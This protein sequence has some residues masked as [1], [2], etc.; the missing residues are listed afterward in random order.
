MQ[1]FPLTCSFATPEDIP[2]LICLVD[3]VFTRFEAPDYPVQGVTEFLKY[4]DESAWI[5]R[6][7]SGAFTIMCKKGEAIAGLIEIREGNHL[8]LLFVDEKYHRLGI[9]THLWQLAL[10]HCLQLFPLLEQISVN[11]SPYA[12]P[13]YEKM[14]FM[15]TTGRQQVNGIIFYPMLFKIPQ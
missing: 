4:I 14:G 3:H 15:Q 6:M 13:F 5:K 9:A 11:S 10:E 1:E 8:S 7:Q 2:D 12:T